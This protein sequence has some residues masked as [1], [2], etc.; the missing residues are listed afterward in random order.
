MWAL[1]VALAGVAGWWY[2]R[3]TLPPTVRL[4]DGRVGFVRE[5]TYGT[6]HVFIDGPLWVRLVGRY[7]P[8]VLSAR[9]GLLRH[10]CGSDEPST[11]VWMEWQFPP[12]NRPPI[13]VAVLDR[14][15]IA[16]E[17]VAVAVSALAESH[18]LLAW[19]L[20][21]YPRRERELRLR[22][23][24][25]ELPDVIPPPG[26]LVPRGVQALGELVVPN[27]NRASRAMPWSA[28]NGPVSVTNDGIVLTMVSL[29]CGGRAGGKVR[30]LASFQVAEAGKATAGWSVGRLEGWGASGNSF[31]TVENF[32]LPDP[33]VLGVGDVLWPDEPDWRLRVEFARTLGYEAGDLVT[34]P[35]VS[36]VLTN[37]PYKTNLNLAVHGAKLNSVELGGTRQVRR[38]MRGAYRPNSDLALEFT[39]PRGVQVGLVRI[40]DDQGRDVRFGHIT[41]ATPT[42]LESGVELHPDTRTVD[43]TVAVQRR[44]VAEFLVRPDWDTSRWAVAS[45]A[46][47][48][49]PEKVTKGAR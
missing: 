9:R 14:H 7:L 1:W 48:Q 17:P 44:R 13:R 37:P 15:G 10:T 38:W 11:V 47:S 21:N 19:R 28:P 36:A 45:S 16:S 39:Q 42:R 46:F 26:V 8:P 33:L 41:L 32:V 6:N 27:P 40:V 18:G 20:E 23:C 30:A 24:A 5:V 25:L 12:T 34:I 4:A 35:S 43:V 49:S 2:W 29:N 22:F 31:Q 3:Q